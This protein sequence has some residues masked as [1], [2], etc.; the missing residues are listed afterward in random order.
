MSQQERL[1]ET[2]HDVEALIESL[3]VLP[4]EPFPLPSEPEPHD[5]WGIVNR[6]Y[7]EDAAD[8][9]CNLMGKMN[10]D[11]DESIV[12]P[13]G[14]M[15][16]RSVLENADLDL[17][18]F[19]IVIGFL[20]GHITEYRDKTQGRGKDKNHDLVVE[21]PLRRSSVFSKSRVENVF[22]SISIKIW[23]PEEID[24]VSEPNEIHTIISEIEDAQSETPT[25]EGRVALPNMVVYGKQA[26]ATA[27]GYFNNPGH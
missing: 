2:E 23:K 5:L 6:D 1:F 8:R 16:D 17:G 24:F 12:T 10:S 13:L 3:G 27:L 7:S 15:G 4:V 19:K 9:M 22:G 20:G 25:D 11:F 14:I 21:L 26:L 18:S